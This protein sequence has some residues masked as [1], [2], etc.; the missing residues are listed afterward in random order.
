MMVLL[1]YGA[2]AAWCRIDRQCDWNCG[3]TSDCNRMNRYWVVEQNDVCHEFLDSL[4]TKKMRTST[5]PIHLQYHSSFLLDIHGPILSQ[6]IPT[7]CILC[8]HC[9]EEQRHRSQLLKQTWF[10]VKRAQK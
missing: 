2:A 7:D 8:G 3:H 1:L 4:R 6:N 10:T 9:I 5:L